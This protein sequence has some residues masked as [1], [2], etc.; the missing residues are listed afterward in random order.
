MSLSTQRLPRRL[1][2]AAAITGLLLGWAGF[3]IGLGYLCLILIF[4]LNDE[5]GLTIMG[6]V[7]FISTVLTLG[8][9]GT[10][11]WHS[12]AS[13]QGKNSKSV[14]LSSF[15]NMAV[16]FIILLMVSVIVYQNNALATLFFPPLLV[17][18]VSLPPL[19]AVLWFSNRQ[20]GIFTWRRILTVLMGS[21]TICAI[22]GIIGEFIFLGLWSMHSST[23]LATLFSLI[24]QFANLGSEQ[25]LL[26]SK[27]SSN[28]AFVFY[29]FVI[30]TPI[31]GAL[32]KSI[33]TVLFAKR[34]SELE[35]FLLGAVAGSG[36]AVLET[37]ILISFGLRYWILIVIL[38]TLGGAIHPLG[39]GL[40]AIG[41]RNVLLFKGRAWS[42]WL[43]RFGIATAVHMMWNTGLLII[44]SLVLTPWLNTTIFETTLW[45]WLVISVISAILF[46]LGIVALGSGYSIAQ[47]GD[48]RLDNHGS[49][50]A[51]FPRTNTYLALWGVVS[52]FAILPA[53]IIGIHLFQ[54]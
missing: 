20:T 49:S 25:H 43:I 10:I 8:T 33:V 34:I 30:L 1:K 45:N 44:I 29:Q 2:Q 27:F 54:N 40:V 21:A 35:S 7:G 31:M 3:V 18:T 26:Q 32:V 4:I 47:W 24:S 23:P 5:S 38:Q 41:L 37:I 19:S 22:T 46:G 9:G 36:F 52:L 53:G 39:A 13:L 48:S 11:F 28:L 16:I 17:A 15:K 6:I 51:F 42:D 12:I 14:P 50:A